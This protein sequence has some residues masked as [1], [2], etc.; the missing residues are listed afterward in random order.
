MSW[1]L[2]DNQTMTKTKG[3]LSFSCLDIKYGILVTGNQFTK[4][5]IMKLIS[6]TSALTRLIVYENPIKLHTQLATIMSGT[7]IGIVSVIIY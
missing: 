3:S 5:V 4:I 6:S 2:V 1:Y 7:L